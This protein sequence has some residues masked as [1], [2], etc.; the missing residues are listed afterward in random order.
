ML[1]KSIDFTNIEYLKSGNAR[2]QLAYKE[3]NVLKIFQILSRYTPILSG[4]I[5]IGIDIPE[6]DLDII[7]HCTDHEMFKL[8]IIKHFSH[9]K[10]F[11]LKRI[12]INGILSTVVR[13]KT[14]H[15]EFEIFAQNIPS[16]KQH[17]FKHMLKEHEILTSMGESFRNQVIQLKLKGIKTEPAFAQLLNLSGNPYTELLE[18]DL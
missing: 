10:D 6:S 18:Y 9:Q 16:E 4:T 8:E 14:D 13:F 11:E 15:F 7:C 5:P 2:Q 3:L 1:L 12:T 17:A